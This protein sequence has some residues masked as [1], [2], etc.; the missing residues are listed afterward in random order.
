MRLRSPA[1]API[2]RT[3]PRF[4]SFNNEP[5]RHVNSSKTVFQDWRGVRISGS[6]GARLE[7]L[8]DRVSDA[9]AAEKPCGSADLSPQR[10]GDGFEDQGIALRR[11]VHNCR[12]EEKIGD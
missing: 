4:T 1:G 12:G 6:P 3:P 7:I 10:R 11:T 9:G 8:G 5:A 2:G